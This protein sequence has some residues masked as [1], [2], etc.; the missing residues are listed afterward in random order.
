[1][2]LLRCRLTPAAAPAIARL[3]A[4]GA[5]TALDLSGNPLLDETTA[6]LLGD[7][8]RA[9]T[10]LT[11]FSLAEAGLWRYAAAGATLVGSLTGHPSLRFLNM[12]AN[13]VRV[14]NAAA[15]A[16]TALAALLL[17]NAPALQTLDISFCQM[18]DDGMG[19]VVEALRRNTYLTKL[20]CSGN[21]ISERF[22]RKQLL[23]AVRANAGLRKLVVNSNGTGE[24]HA[25]REAEAL[26]AA[27]VRSS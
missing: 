25:G 7:A 3:A 21:R 27:R 9:N 16:G 24:T 14:D 17:A 11:A 4:D 6:V 8:L 12:R 26:V 22:A 18:G 13:D 15:V 23:P 20:E 1:V 2:T 5:L 19:P 10:S